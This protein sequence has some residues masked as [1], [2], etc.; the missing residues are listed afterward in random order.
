MSQLNSVTDRETGLKRERRGLKASWLLTISVLEN[1]NIIGDTVASFTLFC[2][3]RR[4]Q[5]NS[6]ASLETCSETNVRG[7][8]FGFVALLVKN[9]WLGHEAAVILA[10]CYITT[11]CLL[12][13]MTSLLSSWT[14]HDG[15]VAF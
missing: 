3:S 1:L 7:F 9:L 6:M 12:K 15:R 8:S 14:E 10:L 13:S 2:P 11:T 5:L 4:R